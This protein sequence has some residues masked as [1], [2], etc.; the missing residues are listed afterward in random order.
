LTVKVHVAGHLKDYTDDSLD[1]ELKGAG[2]VLD[3]VVKLNAKSPTS[4][5]GFSTSTTGSGLTSISTLT[6][7][8]S[9]T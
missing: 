1:L 2:D 5:R 9:G 6:R 7:R 4:E 3:L 8:T